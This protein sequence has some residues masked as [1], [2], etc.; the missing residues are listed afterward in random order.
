MDSP[1]ATE[2]PSKKFTRPDRLPIPR[3]NSAEYATPSTRWRGAWAA[4][5]LRVSRARGAKIMI[6]HTGAVE[7]FKPLHN[8]RCHGRQIEGLLVIMTA[9]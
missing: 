1:R 4:T 5:S 9:A 2:A 8:L 7:A 6:S 3:T